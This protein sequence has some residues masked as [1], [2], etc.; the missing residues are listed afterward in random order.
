[1]EKKKRKLSPVLIIGGT[2][3]VALLVFFGP[4]LYK[5][6]RTA[7]DTLIQPAA[8]LPSR[9]SKL[10]SLGVRLT[11]EQVSY[12]EL[13]FV[14]HFQDAEWRQPGYSFQADSSIAM[15]LVGA[16]GQM[17]MLAKLASQPDDAR[18]P[19]PNDYIRKQNSV[20]TKRATG[21]LKNY[22]AEAIEQKRYDDALQG[23]EILF[24]LQDAVIPYPSE[25]TLLYWYGVNSDLVRQI[26]SLYREPGLTPEMRDRMKTMVSLDLR[27]PS[28]RNIT[29]RVATEMMLTSKK[30]PTLDENDLSALDFLTNHREFP[31]LKSMQMHSAIESRLAEVWIDILETTDFSQS[32]EELGIEIDKKIDK[33]H[34]LMN[35][36]EADYMVAAIQLK[37]E[38][39]GR[40]I[41]R[42]LQARAVMNVVMEGNFKK[43]SITKN[44]SGF[45]Y[46]V[47]IDEDGS[48]W[49]VKCSR[50]NGFG[51][52][53]NLDGFE[54]NQGLGARAF[55]PK[56]NQD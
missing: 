18:L 13:E 44:A 14:P 56:I 6:Y 23:L 50:L 1:M 21:S 11:G 8:A 49:I 12:A 43:G 36:V 31:D 39:Y 7:L 54:I 38:L 16:P 2:I 37:F 32:P 35:E 10:D 22:V 28:L 15:T 4:K 33:R 30:L 24:A 27:V 29:A 52:Y 46:T 55:L 41:A 34:Q 5:D 40:M 48:G 17:E 26:D 3:L 19:S 42:V 9:I 25:A 20:A 45:E 47:D 53:K 51:S